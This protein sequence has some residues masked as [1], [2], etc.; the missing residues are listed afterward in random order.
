MKLAFAALVLATSVAHADDTTLQAT[1]PQRT[2]GIDGAVVM[3][4]GNYADA[5]GVGAGA[6]GRLEFP[7]STGGFVTARIGLI[8]HQVDA[9]MGGSLMFVPIYAG[10]R[11]PLGT[12]GAYLAGELGITFGYASV[13]TQFGRVSDSDSELGI[14]LMAGLRKG[15]LDFRAGLFAPDIDDVHGFMASLGYNFSSF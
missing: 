13:D 8:A 12:S 4:L 11:Q 7:V 3:P 2:F 15:A 1:A 5:A 10:Y 9:T 6:F 14:T